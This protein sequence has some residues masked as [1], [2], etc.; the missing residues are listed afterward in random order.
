M[1]REAVAGG[2]AVMQAAI[3]D[4][5]SFSDYVRSVLGSREQVQF[6]VLL[7]A[8]SIGMFANWLY[9]WMRDE[10]RGSLFD[11]LLHQY[12]K[13]TALAFATFASYAVA[14][15]LSPVLDGAGWGVVINMGFTTGFAIDALVNKSDRQAWTEE[16]RKQQGTKP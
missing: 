9:K 2:V 5:G 1:I 14:T 11:Y 4:G 13:R 10:I 12:P 15:V 8:G 16:E 6:W 7:G 3:N